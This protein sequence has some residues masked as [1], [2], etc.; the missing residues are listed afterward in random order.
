[1]QSLD[2]HSPAHKTPCGRFTL[3]YQQF[4]CSTSDTDD[5]LSDVML[6]MSPNPINADHMEP[7]APIPSS[8]QSIPPTRQ[9]PQLFS[10]H[11]RARSP[12]PH[13]TASQKEPTLLG[14]SALLLTNPPTLTDFLSIYPIWPAATQ[15]PV[16]SD[17]AESDDPHPSDPAI[18]TALSGAT[19]ASSFKRRKGRQPKARKKR[20]V[21]PAE[22]KNKEK[23]Y[24]NRI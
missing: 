16:H 18:T 3:H 11:E 5:E 4:D 22:S 6:P 9:L 20:L 13:L 12:S 7:K 15:V 10:D 14:T 19:T 2:G 8:D 21:Q 17:S 1:M 23:N 24:A